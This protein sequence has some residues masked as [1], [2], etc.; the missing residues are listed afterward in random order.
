MKLEDN[1]NIKFKLDT[2]VKHHKENNFILAEKLYKDILDI[3]PNHLGAIFYLGTLYA[4]SKKFSLAKEFLMR[5]DSLK[6]KDLNINLN[7]GNVFHETGDFDNAI[8][9]FENLINIKQD[10]TLAYFNKGIVLNKLKK[11]QNAN[12]CFMKV[13][14][15]EP[16]NLT[17]HNIIA[18]N[19]IELNQK[20]RAMLYLKKALKID[21]NNKVS[22]KI[23]TDL[24]S[25][26][27]ILNLDKESK[28]EIKD[29]FT[30]LYKKNLINHNQL[31]NNA[32]LFIFD[33]KEYDEIKKLIEQKCNLIENQKV[34][35][36]LK[37]EFFNLILQKSLLRDKFLEEFCNKIR[38]EIILSLDNLADNSS[39]F[40]NFII[41]LAEQCF[42][43]EFIFFQSDLEIEAANSLLNE[44]EKDKN[45]NE[46]KVAILACFTPLSN[47]KII[48]EKLI[49]YQSKNVLFNDL[50]DMQIR[51]PN[52]E[53]ELSHKIDSIGD[54]SNMVSK[55]VKNQYE[56]NPYPRWRFISEGVKSNFINILNSNIKPNKITSNRSF[57]NPNVLIAGCGTG[58]QLEN[59]ITYEN[60]NILAID[61]SRS[62][63][64]Y[65]K[66]KMEEI[67]F[68]K[69]EFMHGD[70]LN[71]A[72]INKKFDVI[73]C[74]GV[75][76]H[77]ENPE[78]G[79]KVLL[80]ILEPYGFL[81]LGLYSEISRK[82]IIEIREI[83][84]KE[85]FSTGIKDIRNSREFIKNNKDNKS[86]QKL[87]YNY[88]FYST[89]SIRDL[90]FHVQE[91]RFT[92]DKISKLL[93][94]LNLEFLGF[95][96]DEVKKKY[97][98]YY[99]EDTN[100]TNIENWNTLESEN[101][102]M[103]ISMYQFWVKKK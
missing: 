12:E 66:R 97:S 35:Q 99:P 34:K 56:F 101:P 5:A 30:F 2:A 40:L 53:K 14:E 19:F 90:I 32:K 48:S 38:K 91:K 68:N 80:K 28:Q 46:Y 1:N 57:F 55:K 70:I 44:I 51:E 102:D 26:L 37:K 29:L 78:D 69:I 92:L 36:I 76:H 87:I 20:N 63:L 18:L 43:N 41:S 93:N 88:D 39:E 3:F 67:N 52:K 50:I 16:K 15:I 89:S 22:I 81:K 74:V 75:L 42:L 103:F 94:S 9:Y 96:D 82:H 45:V 31:F 4:Q 73:E 100:K 25:S 27:K 13:I 47:S 59:A 7:L 17:S 85:N 58:Q 54:I 98:D 8:K 10:F 60:A 71:L 6:P 23:L 64:A 84:K 83:I 49:Y 24:L 86:C 11:Y 62:S 21:F 77:M 61:L 79:L 95:T 33:V 65:A 72:N